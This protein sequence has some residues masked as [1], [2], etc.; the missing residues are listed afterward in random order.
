MSGNITVYA[1]NARLKKRVKE[2]RDHLELWKAEC[3]RLSTRL[4]NLSLMEKPA[5]NVG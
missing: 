3:E 2:L 1:E 5:L 4:E